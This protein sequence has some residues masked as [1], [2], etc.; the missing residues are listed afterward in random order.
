MAKDVFLIPQVLPMEA[1][2]ATTLPDGPEWQYEPKWD[3]FRCLAYIAPGN[4]SL[5]SKTGK[6]LARF[7]P[8]TVAM[9][10]R[11]FAEPCVLDGELVITRD[12]RS[13]FEA[14]QARLHPAASRIER[15]SRETPARYALFDCLQSGTER[16]IDAPLDA[17]RAVLVR[18]LAGVDD[19]GLF[20][21][22]ATF[23][24]A[25]AADWL[26]QSGAATDGVIAK[27]RSDG[28][29]PGER[30]MIK[31]KRRR[32]ADCVVGGFRYASN[33]PIVGSLLLGLYDED[34]RLDHVGFTSG[35]SDEERA[36][37]T[38]QLEK[39][40]EPPGF[41]GRAPGGPSRWSTDRSAEWQP[42]R[43]ELVVEVEF[44]Q[45]TGQRFRHGTR[46]LRWRPD[47]APGQCTME[48]LCG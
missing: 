9:L 5:Y 23:D 46:F 2:I 19:P 33:A 20:L 1:R 36:V 15:L 38:P 48:Q 13:T 47:K 10:A 40:I 30:S 18:L 25:R 12:G 34:G 44:D 35:L 39:M 37:L 4:V 45:V 7:F 17:R 22:D 31:V 32:T 3:G 6:D 42:L 26:A 27:R 43:A 24:R 21:S 14:L 29:H 11:L 16:L 8:E 28:Y 41:T